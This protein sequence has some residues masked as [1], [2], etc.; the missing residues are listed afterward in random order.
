MRGYLFA[1]VTLAF[2]ASSTHAQVSIPESANLKGLPNTPEQLFLRGPL[3]FGPHQLGDATF[4]QLLS[5][6]PKLR[7]LHAI[8]FGFTDRVLESIGKLD[9][10]EELDLE[11]N[12][13]TGDGLRHLVGLKKLR[14]LNL[15]GNA[16]RADAFETLAKL[17]YLTSLSVREHGLVT[18]RVL[19]H[20]GKLV[21]LQELHLSQDTSP[22]TDKGVAHLGNLKQLRNLSLM[23]SGKLTDAGLAQIA[24]FSQ[25]R[26]LSLLYLKSTTPGGLTVLGNLT[27]LRALEI[28]FVPMNEESVRAL[29]KCQ[30]LEHLR[31]TMVSKEPIALEGLAELRSLQVNRPMSS[32]TIRSLAQRKHLEKL[33]LQTVAITDEDLTHLARLSKL[34]WLELDSDRITAASLPTLASMKALR[35]LY[36]T[37][38]ARISPEQWTALG[39][40]SLP[41]CLIARPNPPFANY[42]LPKRYR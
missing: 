22:V 4:Q 37:G 27:E 33:V 19:E 32:E 18:D 12:A 6:V 14:R 7:T 23:K 25:L 38:K 42:H 34:Q 16:I 29:G 2:V 39:Q 15:N 35:V 8:G 21:Q 26:E 41:E 30:K 13:F 10:L 17:S 31:L 36:T 3:R 5:Q 1:V 28:V 40:D 24:K 20:C 9:A 11:G